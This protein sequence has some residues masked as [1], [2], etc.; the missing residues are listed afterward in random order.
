MNNDMIENHQAVVVALKNVRPHSN[1]DRLK[2]AT[3]CGCQ[4]IVGID[5]EEGDVG[6]FFPEGVR[7]SE[8]F[9]TVNDLIRRKDENGNNAGGMFDAN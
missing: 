1:A 7:L 6:I 8:E 9:A 5:S 2:L 3:V 4:I